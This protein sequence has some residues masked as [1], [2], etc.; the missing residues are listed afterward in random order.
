VRESRAF[1]N[2]CLSMVIASLASMACAHTG[3]SPSAPVGRLATA[4]PGLA[5]YEGAATI[6]PLSR[7]ISAEWRIEFAPRSTDSAQLLLNRGLHLQTLRGPS[8]DSYSVSTRDGDQLITVF[9]K[10]ATTLVPTVVDV[11]YAGVLEAPSDSINRLSASWIEL[12]VDSHWHPQVDANRV[13]GRV[14]LTIP[15]GFKLAAS[16]TFQSFADRGFLLT[17]PLPLADIAFSGSPTFVE[18]DSGGTRVL[19]TEVRTP[20]VSGVLSAAESCSSYLDSLYGEKERLPRRT[21][22]LAPRTGPGYARKN[23]IVIT[24]IDTSRV[25]LSRFV[26]HE[27]AHFWSSR[28]NSQGPDNWLNEGFAEFVSAQYVR[29]VI[30]EAAYK[31]IVESWS[32]AARNQPPIWTPDATKRPSALIAYRKAPLFLAQLEEHIGRQQLQRIVQ[33]YM[34]EDVSTTGQLLGLVR[35]VAGPG[36]EMWVREQLAR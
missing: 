5:V 1:R 11:A 13:V 34:V 17:S 7:E 2:Q 23:Y 4:H 35:R 27:L 14:R 24:Q 15:E 25:G 20:L 32:R 12:G 33:R 10:P 30:G 3:V 29:D 22:V 28:A 26:C 21:M 19:Y 36:N 31:E 8:V 9:F 18:T 16:G 6:N